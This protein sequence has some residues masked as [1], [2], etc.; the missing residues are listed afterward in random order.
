MSAACLLERYLDDDG[1]GALPA[2]P[3]KWPLTEQ[4]TIFN[5][6][7]VRDHVREMYY[8]S[9]D[10]DVKPSFAENKRRYFT[11]K[12]FANNAGKEEND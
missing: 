1:G 3:Y 4:Q 8:A 9:E 7:E 11:M 12:K 2:R 5:Y 6:Q 10:E